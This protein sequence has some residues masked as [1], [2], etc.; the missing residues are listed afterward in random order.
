VLTGVVNVALALAALR[1]QTAVASDESTGVDPLRHD[2]RL[3]ASAL[4][5]PD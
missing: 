1:Y 2:A 5:P 3:L 4:G